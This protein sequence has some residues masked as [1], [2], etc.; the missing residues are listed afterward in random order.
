[1]YCL[2]FISEQ[3]ICQN[4]AKLFPEFK[5]MSKITHMK[6]VIEYQNSFRSEVMVRQEFNNRIQR[7]ISY[8]KDELRN[9]IEDNL[10]KK[11]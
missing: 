9:F 5:I 1:M 8:I 3:A 6:K 7:I 10:L 4:T 2:F 11:R